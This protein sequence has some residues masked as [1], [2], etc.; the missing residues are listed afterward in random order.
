MRKADILKFASSIY[1]TADNHAYQKI[2]KQ[3]ADMQVND[4]KNNLI[5]KLRKEM[6]KQSNDKEKKLTTAIEVIFNY[7]KKLI[8]QEKL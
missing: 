4:A 5:D 6:P 3:Q 8:S 2:L 7:D 1:T